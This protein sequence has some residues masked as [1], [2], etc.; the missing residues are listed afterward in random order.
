MNKEKIIQEQRTIEAM[1]RGYI[2]LEGKFANIAKKLGYS[3]ISQNSSNFQQSFL[4][5][6]YGMT[7]DNE[8][9]FP[10][11]DEDDYISEIGYTYEGYSLG[12]NLTINLFF[13]NAEINVRYNGNMIYKEAAGELESYVPHKDWENI[14][15]ILYNKSLNVDKKK[16]QKQVTENIEMAEKRKK[17]ILERLKNKWGI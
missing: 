9:E 13:Y 10:V 16:K 12:Y 4:E 1:K 6:F 11:I 17:E 2:G 7:D 15:E 8:Q 3:I 5:D 14:I